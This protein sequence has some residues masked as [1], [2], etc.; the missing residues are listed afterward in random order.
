M[1][2]DK[3]TIE[4]IKDFIQQAEDHLTERYQELDN[5]AVDKITQIVKNYC[6]ETGIDGLLLPYTSNDCKYAVSVSVTPDN[7]LYFE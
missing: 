4:E 1:D 5:I 3:M 2:F 6:N 7:S